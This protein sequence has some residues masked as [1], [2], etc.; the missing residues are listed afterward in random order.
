[1]DGKTDKLVA[2]SNFYIA[3]YNP[4]DTLHDQAVQ[5]AEIIK[6]ENI[7]VLISNFIFLETVTVLSIR[8]N[9]KIAVEAGTA[10]VKTPH[11]IHF[12]KSLTQQT[13]EIFQKIDKKNMGFVDCSILAVM[14]AEDIKYLLT[15]DQTDFKSLQKAFGFKL[16]PL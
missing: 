10:L 9:R 4:E 11:F 12:D 2:D 7:K 15:F 14:K 3:L 1:M 13:W 8:G 5:A 6:R 16:Y